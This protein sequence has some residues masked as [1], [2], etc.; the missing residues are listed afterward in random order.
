MIVLVPIGPD[1]SGHFA[2]GGYATGSDMSGT[3]GTFGK[4]TIIS[5]KLSL[6]E[7]SGDITIKE[8][9]EPE[10]EVVSKGMYKLK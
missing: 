7:P 6:V 5:K 1:R 4:L 9:D 3:R 8:R 10:K 2:T